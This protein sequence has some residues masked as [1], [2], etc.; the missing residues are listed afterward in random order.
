MGKKIAIGC[1]MKF[2]SLAKA[3]VEELKKLD[4]TTLFPNLDRSDK[5]GDDAMSPEEKIRLAWDEYR[6]MEQADVMYFI[7]PG[8]YMGTSCK[9][10]LGYAL[11]LKIP[12]YFSEPTNDIGLD[13]YPKKFISLDNLIEFKKEF[14]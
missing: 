10:E 1:S 7:L 4:F 3:T 14:D 6:A 9:L 8:G 2:R 12:I 11:A 13:G 5:D